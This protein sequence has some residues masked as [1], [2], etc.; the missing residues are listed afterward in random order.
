[1][2]RWKLLLKSLFAPLAKSNNKKA[3]HRKTTARLWAEQLEERTTPTTISYTTAGNIITQN[4]SGMPIATAIATA[5]GGSQPYDLS[6]AAFPAGFGTGDGLAG[7]YTSDIGSTAPTT[8]LGEGQPATTTGALWDFNNGNVGSQAL[9]TLSTSSVNSRFGA[10]LVNSTG[11]TLN[12]FTLSY[13]GEEWWEG[14]GAT[15]QALDFYYATSATL[16]S[17]PTASATTGYS[18]DT[19]LDFTAPSSGATTATAL[20]GTLA[21][22]QQA[23]NGGVITDTVTGLTWA[24]NTYLV[25]F[26]QSATTGSGD[27]MGVAN[28]SFSAVASALPG[29]S[30]AASASV[31]AGASS[32]TFQVTA[33]SS[34]T[35]YSLTGSPPSWVSINNSGLM[36]FATAPTVSTSTTSTFTINA[37][38]SGGTG[39]QSF[40]VTDLPTIAYATAGSAATQNF[41][42]LPTAS[43]LATA[44]SGSPALGPYDL[45]GTFPNGFGASDG[46]GGWYAQNIGSAGTGMKMAEGAATTTTGALFDFNGANGNALGTISTTSVASAFGAILVN[47][48]GLTLNTFTLSYTGELWW[49]NATTAMNFSYLVN[50]TSLTGGTTVASLG[51]SDPNP[52]SGAVAVD[53]STSSYQTAVS[54]TV[55]GITWAP[56]QTLVIEWDKGT[57]A[58][59]S[60]GLGIA[61]VS[62]AASHVTVPGISSAAGAS[63]YAGVSSTFQVT[64]SNSPTSYSLT[65]APSWVGISNAGLITFTT[66]PVVATTTAYSFSISATNGSGT[67]TPQTFTLTELPTIA[68]ATAGSAATQNFNGLPTASALA[69][70]SS[71]SP[72]LGPYDLTGTFPNGFGAS[73]GLGGWYAQNI[74]SAGTGMKMAEGAA[75]TT[76]GALFGF[77]GANGNALGTISSTSVASAFGAILVN[78]TGQTLNTFTLSYTGEVW[79]Q[80]A[81]TAMNFSYLVN[82]TSLTGGTPVAS[83]GFSD[84]N[85]G[86][87]GVAVDGSTSSYQTAVSGTVNGITWAPG[88]TLVLDWD[89][90]TGASGSDGLGIS[91][92]SFAASLVTTPGI[93]SAASASVYAGATSTF[94]VAATGSPTSYSL[95]GAPTWAA[96]SN[97]GLITFTAPSAVATTTA[98]SFSITATNGSGTGAPQAFTLTELPTIAYTTAGSA[99][100]QNFSALPTTAQV[101][102]ASS[103]GVGPYDLTGTFANGFGASDGL[104]GWYS[105]NIGKRGVRQ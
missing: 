43:A 61:N 7:W 102:T 53:G 45:T 69:T 99:A 34:P 48:T 77:N 40:T 71:G 51:F 31:Y 73:D 88:Q 72:A 81:T 8:K 68:Y 95:T 58:G 96:I 90:G 93:T 82:G 54:G 9:G 24:S 37:T 80:N 33:T 19:K 13:T 87:G 2:C 60:D 28:L 21:A 50:G 46:L 27:G 16:P 79:W 56:G 30:S 26:W 49:Q 18:P 64:A 25:V 105:E 55:N 94:Q 89:K 11:A 52:G 47:N 75:T 32:S 91:N 59:G 57:G 44:S 6:A 62:F 98:Y 15:A 3:T 38:N 22:N 97:A 83:L 23:A 86:S 29:I 14:T 65:G 104:A 85:P 17:F 101:V 39:T 78:N 70:A 74:G 100:T 103:L 12:Q 20:D 63:V 4:F 1:M 41:S 76:T 42:A 67:G 66:P 5:S 92:V 10:I 35:S 84:P 36:T